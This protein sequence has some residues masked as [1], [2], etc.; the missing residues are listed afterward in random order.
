PNGL[1]LRALALQTDLVNA[2]GLAGMT[3]HDHERWHI[4]HDLRTTTDDRHLPDPAKLMY[5]RQPANDSMILHH[6]MP[7][8]RA[9]VAKDDMIADDAIVRD[10]RIREKAAVRPN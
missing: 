7:G 9:I 1:R 8:Q 4:L 6:T 10:V 5:R 2:A 3:I